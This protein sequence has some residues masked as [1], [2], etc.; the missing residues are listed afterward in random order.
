[1]TKETEE[2]EELKKAKETDITNSKS[3]IKTDLE[4]LS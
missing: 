1:L 2:T 3:D 4:K